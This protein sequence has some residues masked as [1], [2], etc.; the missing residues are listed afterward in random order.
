MLARLIAFDTT[1]RNSNLEL[2]GFVRGYL[3]AQ[4]VSYRVSLNEDGAKANIH[5]II[6]PQAPGGIALSGHVDTVPVDGQSWSGDP[7]SLR[8]RDGKLYARGACDMKGFVASFLAAVPDIKR[9]TLTRPVH[10]FVSYDEEVGC[11][12]ARRL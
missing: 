7:F 11:A 4:G 9:R 3:D 10:L 1:S 8:R 5:A 12:G 6:G 2:I